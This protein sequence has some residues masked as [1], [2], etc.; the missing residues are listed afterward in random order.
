M[1]GTK[2][3]PLQLLYQGQPTTSVQSFVPPF[4]GE[5]HLRMDFPNTDTSRSG[6]WFVP[7]L[8]LV[9]TTTFFAALGVSAGSALVVE[10]LS[11]PGGGIIHGPREDESQVLETVPLTIHS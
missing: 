8:Q 6:P 9:S 7:L 3:S 5:N 10:F 4:P 1:L 2:H 11:L